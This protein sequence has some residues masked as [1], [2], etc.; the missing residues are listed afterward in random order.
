MGGA[1]GGGAGCVPVGAAVR[2]QRL[3]DG[4]NQYGALG[5]RTRRR[6]AAPGAPEGQ[7]ESGTGQA[8]GRVKDK[9]CDSNA[10]N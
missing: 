1:G 9:Q 10:N 8:L 6:R 3:S 7:E 4:A 5:T 2:G